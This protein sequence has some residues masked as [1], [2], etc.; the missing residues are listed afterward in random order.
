MCY[1]QLKICFLE[2]P[3]DENVNPLMRKAVFLRELVHGRAGP[4]IG[5]KRAIPLPAVK[6]LPRRNPHRPAGIEIDQLQE[7]FVSEQLFELFDLRH[8][9]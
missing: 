5:H 6:A 2:M 4:V 3:F 8:A 1:K 7:L 9:G